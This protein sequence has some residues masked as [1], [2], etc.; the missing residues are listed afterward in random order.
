MQKY[1]SYY[2]LWV[3]LPVCTIQ[4]QFDN[5]EIPHAHIYRSAYHGPWLWHD[6]CLISGGQWWDQISEYV[7]RN[8]L[9]SDFCTWD[10]QHKNLHNG[11]NWFYHLVEFTCNEFCEQTVPKMW[12]LRV[13]QF[14]AVEMVCEWIS[15]ASDSLITWVTLGFHISVFNQSAKI[16]AIPE[17]CSLFSFP[18]FPHPIQL[19]AISQTPVLLS[20]QRFT[21]FVLCHK[22]EQIFEHST[23]CLESRISNFS[24]VYVVR[25]PAWQ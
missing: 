10:G 14:I 16:A 18:I 1:I 20:S 21:C 23:G 19:V 4:S 17:S 24:E 2:V 8:T 9:H 22:Q 11:W 15:V 5:D 12:N 13:H 3:W 6:T 25:S 7:H